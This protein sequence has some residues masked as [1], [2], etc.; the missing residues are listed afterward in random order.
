MSQRQK[1]IEAILNNHKDVA[2]EDACKVATWLGFTHE[3]GKGSHKAY[4][5]IGEPTQLNFQNRNGRIVPYQARQLADM[6][7]RYWEPEK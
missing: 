2:F 6:I 3:G 7:R 1:L 5:R 4:K